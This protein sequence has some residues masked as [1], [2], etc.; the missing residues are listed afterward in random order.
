MCQILIQIKKNH[1]AIMI[2]FYVKQFMIKTANHYLHF[3]LDQT[4]LIS[5]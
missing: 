1:V 5:N 2:L 3:L 4:K